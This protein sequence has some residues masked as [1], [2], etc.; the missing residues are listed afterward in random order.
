MQVYDHILIATDVNPNS[1]NMFARAMNIANIHNARVSLVHA[2]EPIAFGGYGYIDVQTVENDMLALGKKKLIEIGRAFSIPESD[3]Y[4]AVSTTRDYI[5]E[6]SKEINADLIIVGSHSK[7]GVFS[8]LG[9][10]SNAI[11]QHAD[12]DVLIIQYEDMLNE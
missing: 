3:Q 7:P 5:L 10:T 12:C 6:I 11:T 2:I 9:T 4:V 1:K 8:R